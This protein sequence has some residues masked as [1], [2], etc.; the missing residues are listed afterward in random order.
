GVTSGVTTP[1]NTKVSA[2]VGVFNVAPGEGH[3]R[4]NN[5]TFT[6]RAAR[7]GRGD[8]GFAVE[9]NQFIGVAY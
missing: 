7:G 3:R 2:M 5:N 9:G 8:R 4:S 1:P 6:T